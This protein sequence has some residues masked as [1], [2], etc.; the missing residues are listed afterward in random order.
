M[1]SSEGWR[2]SR[3]QGDSKIAS[4][5]DTLDDGAMVLLVMRGN[6]GERFTIGEIKLEVLV[7]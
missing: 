7:V 6:V 5:L 4:L 1:I 3:S 2:K